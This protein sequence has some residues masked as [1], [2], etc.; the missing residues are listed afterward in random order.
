M[1][2]YEATSEQQAQQM[3]QD[4]RD[5][6]RRAMYICLREGRDYEVRVWGVARNHR[7]PSI[8]EAMRHI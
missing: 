7:M 3:V 8:M 4:A 6:G 2:T 1:R 5:Q